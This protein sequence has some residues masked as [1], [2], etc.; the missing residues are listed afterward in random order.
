MSEM[1]TPF[2]AAIT[3]F[4]SSKNLGQSCSVARAARAR[5]RATAAA[6]TRTRRI[7]QGAVG[8]APVGAHR[9]RPPNQVCRDLYHF[10]FALTPLLA[11]VAVRSSSTPAFCAPSPHLTASRAG[12]RNRRPTRPRRKLVVPTNLLASTRDTRLGLLSPVTS[13]SRL[14]APTPPRA[15][16]Q[17]ARAGAMRDALCKQ[18]L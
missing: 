12:Y 9:A 11:R 5:A 7:L 8:R 15:R 2:R 1:W 14:R 3:R 16:P 13:T 4:S 17:P 18:A 6:R 10:D